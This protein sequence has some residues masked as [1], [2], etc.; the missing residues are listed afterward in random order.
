M[1]TDL[2]L[3][4]PVAESALTAI[5][6]NL[7]RNAAAAV[8]GASDRRILLR[9]DSYR[10]VT[11]RRMVSLAIAD[12]ATGSLTLE[13]IERRDSQRGL[14]IVRDLVRRWGG[15]MVVQKESAPLVKSIGVVFSATEVKP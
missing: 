14:G 6:V 10:D 13:D 4:L 5:V 3:A 1:V 7:L 12:S 11:G 8:G 15:F 9:V 2:D